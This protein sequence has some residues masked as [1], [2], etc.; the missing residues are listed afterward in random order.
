ML[1]RRL[2]LTLLAAL[3]PSY[4]FPQDAIDDPR[5][6]ELAPDMLKSADAIAKDMG[7][8]LN[9][10]HD[11]VKVV[12]QILANIEAE[13]RKTKSKDGLFGVA[14]IFGTYIIAV[15][16]RNTERGI[17]R[18]DHPVLGPESFP[19]RWRSQDITPVNWCVKRIF[20]G[21]A[22]NVWTKYQALVLAKLP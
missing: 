7:L 14:F 15:I 21:P 13:Y 5:L 1:S 8:S 22:D 16:E 6:R 2:T 11:S 12:E 10:R 4:A 18:K 9:Y 19:F 20:D 17:W 3:L